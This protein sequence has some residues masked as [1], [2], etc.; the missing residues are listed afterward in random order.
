MK[1]C[2]YSTMFS[3]KTK[4]WILELVKKLQYF[5]ILG[6]CTI[7]L[8]IQVYLCLDKYVSVPTY[9][10]SYIIEQNKVVFIINILI[11]IFCS[12]ADFP[13]ITFCKSEDSYRQDVLQYNGIP[14]EEYYSGNILFHL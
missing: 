1:R 12:K 5:F 11:F 7:V 8:V 13:E 9:I 4:I 10:S 2:N 6:N 3:D 14:D